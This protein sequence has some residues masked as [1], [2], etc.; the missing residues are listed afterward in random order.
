MKIGEGRLVLELAK[1]PRIT[2]RGNQPVGGEKKHRKKRG[3]GLL[4]P[5]AGSGEG[6]GRQLRALSLVQPRV[7][8]GR[9][10]RGCDGGRWNCTGLCQELRKSFALPREE[11]DLRQLEFSTADFR[12]LLFPG[13]TW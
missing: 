1:R 9:A 4:C 10:D 5:P 3:L 13:R 8:G 7:R 6:E 12:A 11:L 2:N